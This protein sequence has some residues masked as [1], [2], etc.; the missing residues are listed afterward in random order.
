MRWQRRRPVDLS[1][2]VSSFP[3][4]TCSSQIPRNPLAQHV[5]RRP[6]DC[7]APTSAEA[8]TIRAPSKSQLA[9]CPSLTILAHERAI[10]GHV[11]KNH[12]RSPTS[13]A[14]NP[15]PHVSTGSWLRIVLRFG[16]T[17][18]PHNSG[19]EPSRLAECNAVFCHHLGPAVCPRGI[20]LH[21]VP[22][23]VHLS[24]R[25]RICRQPLTGPC[26]GSTRL[27]APLTPSAWPR[28][29]E[30]QAAGRAVISAVP[31]RRTPLQIHS[32]IQPQLQQHERERPLRIATARAGRG[33]SKPGGRHGDR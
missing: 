14:P 24:S 1:H 30:A 10:Q 23:T 26:T 29:L 33:N 7:V 5:P 15:R 31:T 32:P 9:A 4:A 22:C 16:R 20:L 3:P 2:F 8:R 11:D 27:P 12:P 18:H 13:G 6:P 17:A 19:L 21:P 25:A 28:H